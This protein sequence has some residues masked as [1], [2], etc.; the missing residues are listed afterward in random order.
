[1]VLITATWI[2]TLQIRSR[3][4]FVAIV[5]KRSDDSIG[6][7]DVHCTSRRGTQ[8]WVVHIAQD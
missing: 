3:L 7:T 8:I 6:E 1:M 4:K 2:D 5:G